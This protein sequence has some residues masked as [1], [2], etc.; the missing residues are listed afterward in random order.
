MQPI[1]TGLQ[2]KTN[3][4][5]HTYF[6]TNMHEA[7]LWYAFLCQF[8]HHCCGN[9][10]PIFFTIFDDNKD[11]EF[12]EV[13]ADIFALLFDRLFCWF[14]HIPPDFFLPFLHHFFTNFCA[15]F[16]RFL[17]LIF[18]NVLGVTRGKVAVTLRGVF[19]KKNGIFWE[20][21]PKWGGGGVTPIP[22]TFGKLPRHFWH[23]KFI[24]R[25]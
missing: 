14:F 7:M 22:K 20:F 21:F 11:E 12:F 1:K 16:C 19:Q 10:L 25:C 24:L 15:V 8:S 18:P 23:A 6:A 9:F 5:L 4:S 2:K 17:F 13:F 3:P